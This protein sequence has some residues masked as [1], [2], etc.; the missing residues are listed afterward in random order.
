MTA[1]SVRREVS[2]GLPPIGTE[3]T[4]KAI[5]KWTRMRDADWHYI[6]PGKPQQREFVE[7]FMTVR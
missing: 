5:L 2:G 7:G 3:L 1:S 6:A 4:S